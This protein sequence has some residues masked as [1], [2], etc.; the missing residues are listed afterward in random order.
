MHSI[1][2]ATC[3]E[4]EPGFGCGSIASIMLHKVLV[5]GH[6][7]DSFKLTSTNGNKA[8]EPSFG[9][10]QNLFDQRALHT[11]GSRYA[12]NHA[13]TKLDEVRVVLGTSSAL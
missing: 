4:P 5:A 1:G 2:R 11:Y 3:E 8:T 7:H 12:T 13:N 10:T 9:S 6:L